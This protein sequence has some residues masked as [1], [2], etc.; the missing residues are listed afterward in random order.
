M[1]F[2]K[3]LTPRGGYVLGARTPHEFLRMVLILLLDSTGRTI[4]QVRNRKT[5]PARLDFLFSYLTMGAF[6]TNFSIAT[7]EF[8]NF[9]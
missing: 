8:L 2:V 6:Y 5:G 4:H 1:G 9:L 7:P 3:S